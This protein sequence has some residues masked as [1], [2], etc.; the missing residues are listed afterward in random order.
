MDDLYQWSD[1]ILYFAVQSLMTR[2][3]D[4]YILRVENSCQF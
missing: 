2:V 3:T 4:C 1:M